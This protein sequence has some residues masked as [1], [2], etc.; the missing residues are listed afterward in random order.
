[1]RYTGPK[2][3]LERREGESLDL[4]SLGSKSRNK[5]LNVPPGMHGQKGSKK[6][7]D[8]A[9]QLRAKQ[10]AKRIY[11]LSEKQFRRY[12]EFGKREKGKTGDV[13]LQ[14]L[15]CRLDNAIFRLGFA[16][17]RAAA[18]QY[19]SH[20]HILVNGKKLNIPSY[21]VKVEDVMTVD[22]KVKTIQKDKD[23]PVWIEKQGAAGKVVKLPERSDIETTVDDQ[24][25]VE[26]YSR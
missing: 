20:G 11:G 1:M 22:S 15:E 23:A 7:S 13:M 3:R 9:V 5:R 14:M 24:L 8:Y 19:V 16:P 18:R 12:F 4:K 25:I 10:K 2:H 6:Q 17:T 26:F 21:Q